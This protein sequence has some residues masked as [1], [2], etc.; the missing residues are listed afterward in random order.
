MLG[1]SGTGCFIAGIAIGFILAGALGLFIFFHC[2]P[3]VRDSTRSTLR[4]IW[5]PVKSG[6]DSTLDVPASPPAN[7]P[8]EPQIPEVQP[9]PRGNYHPAP[10]P[11]PVVP[12]AARGT[13]VPAPRPAPPAAPQPASQPL[14]RARIEINL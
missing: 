7:R 1:C 14:P 6:V 11:R 8:A 10:A 9:A 3:D 2:N 12:A 13:A 5:G 4:Q